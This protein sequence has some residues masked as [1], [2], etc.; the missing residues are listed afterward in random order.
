MGEHDHHMKFRPANRNKHEISSLKIEDVRDLGTTYQQQQG[1]YIWSHYKHLL[2][3][4]EATM[5]FF[6]IVKPNAPLR[7]HV[8]GCFIAAPNKCSE[9]V[10]Y[11][12]VSL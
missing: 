8:Y 4:H 12:V 11:H 10:F 9:K 2:F 7:V 3:T 6:Y 1:G 5:E